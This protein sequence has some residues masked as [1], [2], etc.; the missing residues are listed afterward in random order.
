MAK[1]GLDFDNTLVLYDKQFHRTALAQGLI[2]KNVP[3]NKVA[4]RNYLRQRGRDHEFTLLQGEVYGLGL[5]DIK[6]IT[7]VIETLKKLKDNGNELCII[8]HKTITPFKGPKY[9]LR[10][11]AR[12]WLKQ[13]KFITKDGLGIDNKNIFF[14]STK[15]EKIERIHKERCEYFVDDLPEILEKINR[16]V[17]RILY[18]G[19]NEMIDIKGVHAIRKWKDLEKIVK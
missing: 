8:S 12:K 1:I 14:E 13:N 5:L 3:A 15:E 11:A 16:D 6:P 4:I 19:E 9:K 2:G 17:K 10:G 7:G 18:C